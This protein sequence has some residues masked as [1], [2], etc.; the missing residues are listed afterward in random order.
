MES[1]IWFWV[2]FF[3]KILILKIRPHSSP[4]LTNSEWNQQLINNIWLTR[5][6][7]FFSFSFK[8]LHFSSNSSSTPKKNQELSSGSHFLN[9]QNWFHFWRWDPIFD[10]ILLTRIRTNGSYL[11]YPY[12]CHCLDSLLFSFKLLVPS[13]INYVKDINIFSNAWKLNPASQHLQTQEN[14]L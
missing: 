2:W 3:N 1:R 6:S 11:H 12:Y 7:S 10:S 9:K 14:G 5:S 8:D 13:L 4:M